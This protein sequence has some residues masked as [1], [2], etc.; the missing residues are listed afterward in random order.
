VLYNYLSIYSLGLGWK[1]FIF[2]DLPLM[3][4]WHAMK[5]NPLERNGIQGCR[6]DDSSKARYPNEADTFLSGQPPV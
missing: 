4:G 1:H 6:R 3:Q 5:P 2:P